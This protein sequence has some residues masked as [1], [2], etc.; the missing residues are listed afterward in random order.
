MI[1]KISV[2]LFLTLTTFGFA[3]QHYEANH[4]EI[5]IDQIGTSGNGGR[6]GTEFS[7]MLKIIPSRLDGPVKRVGTSSPDSEINTINNNYFQVGLYAGA[8]Q[9]LSFF[10]ETTNGTYYWANRNFE[11]GNNF[12]FN[13]RLFDSIQAQGHLV[14]VNGRP[15]KFI[16]PADYENLI[17]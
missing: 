13:Q 2:L 16:R 6:E 5:F 3:G 15:T 1:K 11:S 14:Q 9:E 7:V 12:V 4:C 8:T 10:V 17:S